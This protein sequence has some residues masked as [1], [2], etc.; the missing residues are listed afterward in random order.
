MPKTKWLAP[1][2]DAPDP[3][4]YARRQRETPADAGDAVMIPAVG[5]DPMAYALAMIADALKTI[6]TQDSGAA[7]RLAGIQRFLLNQEQ[8]RPHENLFNPPLYS[9]FNP[10]GERDSPRPELKCKIIWVGYELTK[11]GLTKAEITLLN[12]LQPGSFR[13][14]KAD[15]RTIPFTVAAKEN[16]GGQLERLTVHFPCKGSEDRQNHNSMVAYLS[17]V[18]GEQLSTDRLLKQISD[19]KGQL[20]ARSAN[21]AAT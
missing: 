3:V 18:Y 9:H 17:E 6:K 15:G 1:D 19:L 10:E 20:D 8:T 2:E 16:D 11:D 21:A 14:T 7:E 13:V 5:S 12:R 4:D